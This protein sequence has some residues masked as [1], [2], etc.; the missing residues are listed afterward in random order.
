MSKVIIPTIEEL[1]AIKTGQSLPLKS[2]L[3]LLTTGDV[4]K[5]AREFT[6]LHVEAALKAASKDAELRG[7]WGDEEDWH[8]DVL[9]A[10]D[11]DGS[12]IDVT[13]DKDSI[14]NSYP[15]ENIK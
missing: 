10:R 13:V 12:W 6:K 9:Q 2:N 8:N 1:I 11:E 7:N 3:Y 15:S 14:L 5:V 4:M